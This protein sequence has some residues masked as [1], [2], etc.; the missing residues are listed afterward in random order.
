[1]KIT[2]VKAETLKGQYISEVIVRVVTDDGA[3]GLGESWWGLAASP[4]VAAVNDLFAPTLIGQDPDRVEYLWDR[5]YRHGYRYGTEGAVMC[6]LSGID[7]ALW[8]L[9]GKVLDRSVVNLLGGPMY[10]GVRAYAS[11]PPFRGREKRIRQE[12]ARAV[13]AGFTAIKLHETEVADVAAARDE[14]GPDVALMLD[15]NGHWNLNQAVDM[16][17]RLAEFDLVW[18]EEPIF[19]MQDHEALVRLTGLTDMPLAAGENEYSLRSFQRLMTCGAARYVQPEITKVGGLTAARKIGVLAEL[20]NA[21]LCPHC[22]CQGPVLMANLHWLFSQ[23]N[24]AWMEVPFVRDDF[25][26]SGVKRP[27]LKDGR[28][29]PPADRPG[30]G[31]TL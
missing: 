25:F 22:F 17:R 1:M 9:K 14:V 8:D 31:V 30:F 27:E 15:V 24:M 7:M 19:P 11:M 5:M 23:P 26:P 6:A 4:I 18:L 20:N 10:D 2:E 3:I 21:I 12:C 16:A 28:V 13:E 29:L